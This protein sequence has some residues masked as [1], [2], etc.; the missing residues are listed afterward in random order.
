MSTFKSLFAAFISIPSNLLISRNMLHVYT[1]LWT[2]SETVRTFTAIV[3]VIDGTCNRNFTVILAQF[4]T[5][6]DSYLHGMNNLS[7]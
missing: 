7:T 2:E 5:R 6:H 1:L 4:P 3:T